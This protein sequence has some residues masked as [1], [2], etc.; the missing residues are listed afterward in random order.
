MKTNNNA[1]EKTD[2]DLLLRVGILYQ[3]L[4]NGIVRPDVPNRFEEVF[5]ERKHLNGAPFGMR[6]VCRI[7]DEGNIQSP[8]ESNR[9]EFSGTGMPRGEILEVLGDPASNDA[10]MKGIMVM[11]HLSEQFPKSVLDELQKFS[12]EVSQEEI[13]KAISQGRA[14]YRDLNVVTIDGEDTKD[15]DDGLSMKREGGKFILGVHIADVA[16]YV[17]EG[18]ALDREALDRGTSVY[19]ADRVIPMLPTVLSNNLCSLNPGKPR[20]V[21]SVTLAFDSDAN[22]QSFHITESII[23]S[24][25]RL[26]Y[27]E[28]FQTLSDSDESHLPKHIKPHKEMLFDIHQLAQKLR[29]KRFHNGAIDFDLTET[30]LILDANK[31]VIN[32]LPADRNYADEMIEE[33]MIACNE[34]I[35]SHFESIHIPFIYRIH[36]SADSEKIQTLIDL[37]RRLGEKIRLPEKPS[38]KQIQQLITQISEKPHKETLL[39]M[40]LRAMP[41]ARYA[42]KNLGHYGLALKHYC[43]FTSPIRRYPDLF[44]HRVIKASVNETPFSKRWKQSTAFISEQSTDREINA[45]IAERESVDYKIAEYM[46]NHIGEVYEGIVSGI[47]NFGLFIRLSNTAE[48]MAPFRT[49]RGYYEFLEEQMAVKVPNSKQ[50][51]RI[52]DF[53]TVKVIHAD[54]IARRIEFLLEE[55]PTSGKVLDPSNRNKHKS[56]KKYLKANKKRK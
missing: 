32:I 2:P 23:E 12:N 25:E 43:H 26:T 7:I 54:L 39:H 6:V 42:D 51:I 36:Q 11:H 10:T 8:I 40:I 44:I 27:T 49:M 47:M 9:D 3:N 35:A 14:D 4:V 33:C 5:I 15:I 13:Q 41:K 1:I 19:M 48:G 55:K 24:R 46:S 56:K 17:T 28:V 53:V 20:F 29:K 37:A 45:M 38:S 52:G 16:H 30:K 50:I 18:S 21:L 34:A 31:N 22:L